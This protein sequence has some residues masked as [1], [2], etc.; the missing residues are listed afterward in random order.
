MPAP[1]ISSVSEIWS[2][3]VASI[4]QFHVRE[5]KRIFR[6]IMTV[7]DA[8]PLEVT[9]GIGNF[10][11]PGL[12]ATYV[13]AEGSEYDIGARCI[14]VAPKQDQ[15]CPY[16]WTVECDYTSKRNAVKRF[17]DDP[18]KEGSGQNKGDMSE[19]NPLLQAPDIAWSTQKF[20]RLLLW[21]RSSRLP[22]ANSAGEK[23]KTPIMVDDTRF[24][25]TITKNQ[26]FYDP[27]L[28]FPYID[29]V[30]SQP[31]IFNLAAQLCKLDQVNG[32][33]VYDRNLWYWKVTYVVHVRPWR[34]TTNDPPPWNVRALDE[35]T[36]QLDANDNP[37][38]IYDKKT[39]LPVS[40]AVP[41]DG[42]GHPLTLTPPVTYVYWPNTQNGFQLYDQT[43]FNDLQVLKVPT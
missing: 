39:G 30:N 7:F 9:A 31:W 25:L 2:G 3:R 13:G 36:W 23:F 8:G 14:K 34:D 19:T 35:G 6:V 22:I 37:S 29:T 20:Q 1:R 33:S 18:N 38:V 43:D 27:G 16:I 32:T 40:N 41:L 15:E 28:Y 5:Y 12:G 17:S 11:I 10:A 4:D 24:V 26:S 42:T 21:D